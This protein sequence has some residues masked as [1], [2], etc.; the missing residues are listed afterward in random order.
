[1]IPVR[2]LRTTCVSSNTWRRNS[3]SCQ[4]SAMRGSV[5][6]AWSRARARLGPSFAP[7][8]RLSLPEPTGCTT[9]NAAAS[10]W[11]SVSARSSARTAE[12][13]G[14]ARTPEPRRARVVAHHCRDIRRR[15]LVGRLSS[16]LTL[17]L[18]R[19]EGATVWDTDGR[20]FTDFTM[21]WGSVIL[22]HAH[23]AIVEAVRR[24]AA[25]G[26]NFAYVTDASLE[27]AEEL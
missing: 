18:A 14:I 1:M 10:G 12:V 25:L 11:K 19:G 15:P 16:E 13:A 4:S 2:G 23:P 24:R 20:A 26:S 17:V 21:G 9:A 6:A 27:L 22:G 3:R 8:S 7:T 5:P